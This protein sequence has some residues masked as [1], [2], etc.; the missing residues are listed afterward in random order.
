M[1]NRQSIEEPA[2]TGDQTN[3]SAVEC[4][5]RSFGLSFSLSLV[6]ALSLL[7]ESCFVLQTGQSLL[8]SCLEL[9]VAQLF[10]LGSFN[11]LALDASK[12]NLSR[13]AKPPFNAWW[14]TC[15]CWVSFQAAYLGNL[16]GCQSRLWSLWFRS[17]LQVKGVK[18]ICATCPVTIAKLPF[19]HWLSLCDVTLQSK[20]SS[21]QWPVISVRQHWRKMKAIAAVSLT[22]V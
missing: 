9:E 17:Q 1:G 16:R 14:C 2:E 6:V 18:L 8:S 15:G 7:G 21:C 11:S 20:L 10:G 13:S 22:V 3:A 12:I 4:F 5:S 19:I